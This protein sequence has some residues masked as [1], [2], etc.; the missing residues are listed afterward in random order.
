MNEDL[1]ETLKDINRPERYTDSTTG[2]DLID[3]CPELGIDFAQAAK[4]N[5]F[6]YLRRAGKKEGSTA[7]K[8]YLK[9]EIYLKRLIE[10]ERKKTEDTPQQNDT[11]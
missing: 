5:V 4:F 9:A 3:L 6:K 10:I 2:R 1:K 8:D 11:V 7:L